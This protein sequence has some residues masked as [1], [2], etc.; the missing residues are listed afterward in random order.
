MPLFYLYILSAC[1]LDFRLKPKHLLLTFPFFL[2][3]IALIFRFYA[4]SN[5]NKNLFLKN[6]DQMPEPV[7]F[8]LLGAILYVIYI[9]AI[10]KA[11]KKYKE[12]YLEN[13]TN[14]NTLTY[15]WL[16]QISAVSLFA[17]SIVVVKNLLRYSEY[18]DFFIWANVIVGMIVLS[19]LCWF[20]LTVM[21]QP[22][23]FRGIDSQ[24]PLVREIVFKPE[25][26]LEK[27]ERDSEQH[28]NITARVN[29]LRNFM[30]ENE[31]FLNP[32]LTIQELAGKIALPVRDLSILI[33]HHMN[34][35]FFDFINEYRIRKAMEVL[36]DPAK[37]NLTILEILY[38]VGFNSKS[39]FNTS[40]K[41]YTKL[42]PTEY[43]NNSKTEL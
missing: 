36:I 38:E 5:A 18:A 11:L 15:K 22:E 9:V 29:Q 27:A 37:K 30:S 24:L 28:P 8:Q 35:H 31:P 34:L 26:N 21:Y 41:K 4:A 10:F 7:F 12:I 1:Y 20:V 32:S 14:P 16:F 43:R 19:V 13:Y 25:I 40:F 17:H 23:L 33:N 6:F 3:N 39:S 42:T 2:F